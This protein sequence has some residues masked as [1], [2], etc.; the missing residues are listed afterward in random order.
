VQS[1]HLDLNH[2][3]EHAC[4]FGILNEKKRAQKKARINGPLN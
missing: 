4:K 1:Q 3:K 2:Y